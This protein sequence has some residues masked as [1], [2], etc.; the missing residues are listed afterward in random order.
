[1]PQPTVEIRGD[2]GAQSKSVGEI[3]FACQ[4]VGIMKVGFIIDPTKTGS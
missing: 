1:V 4:Q 2:A 3:L